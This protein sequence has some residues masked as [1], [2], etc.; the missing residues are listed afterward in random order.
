MAIISVETHNTLDQFRIKCNQISTLIGDSTD[1]ASFSTNSNIISAIREIL[2]TDKS[3][4]AINQIIEG[5]A[6]WNMTPFTVSDTPASILYTKGGIEV[7][8]VL[9]WDI[10]GNVTTILYQYK[11]SGNFITKLT[12]TIAYDGTTGNVSSIT[13]S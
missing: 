5:A 12:E 3:A 7:K 6:G 8:T 2:G 9:T 1:L 4:V 13:W 10:N 11:E